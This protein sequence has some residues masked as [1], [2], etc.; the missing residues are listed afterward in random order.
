VESYE[1]TW[2]SKWLVDCWVGSVH[3]RNDDAWAFFDVFSPCA[4]K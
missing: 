1:Y 4:S 3:T 2:N